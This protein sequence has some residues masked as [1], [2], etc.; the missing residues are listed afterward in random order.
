MFIYHEDLSCRGYYVMLNPDIFGEHAAFMFRLQAVILLGLL[1]SLEME[2]VSSA[3]K[4]VNYFT[5]DMTSHSPPANK[6]DKV[7]SKQTSATST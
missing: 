1:L 4:S 6:K 7:L 5:I 2:A 3:T